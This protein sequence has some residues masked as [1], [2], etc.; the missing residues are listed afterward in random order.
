MLPG[1]AHADLLPLLLC[2]LQSP[3]PKLSE[4]RAVPCGLTQTSIP[5]GPRSS[6]THALLRAGL[7][8][9]RVHSYRGF[10][11]A[12]NGAS[13][14][15]TTYF[16][17]PLYES[18]S[19]LTRV[20]DPC[21]EGESSHLLTNPWAQGLMELPGTRQICRSTGLWLCPPA[22]VGSPGACRAQGCGDGKG[23]E[24]EEVIRMWYEVGCSCFQQS[25]LPA[26]NAVLPGSLICGYTAF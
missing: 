16:Q 25:V 4:Q 6:V 13:G 20:N 18:L 8:R 19:L 5:G 15:W 23:K 1:A 14:F 21:Q 26:G 9:A 22:R 3:R 7:P 11:E 12:P 17:S 2:I 24:P 10:V